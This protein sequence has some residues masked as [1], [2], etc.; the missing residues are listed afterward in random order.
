MTGDIVSKRDVS[1]WE[2]VELCARTWGVTASD[3]YSKERIREYVEARC[4]AAYLLRHKLNMTYTNIGKA[5]HTFHSSAIDRTR[6]AGTWIRRG[7]NVRIRTIAGSVECRFAE[8]LERLSSEID[9]L[10]AKRR[11]ADFGGECA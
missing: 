5:L 3:I 7:R 2:I 6:R 11:E 1:S 10:A 8:A 9:T 4:A